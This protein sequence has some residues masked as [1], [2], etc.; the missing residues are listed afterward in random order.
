LGDAWMPG[1]GCVQA[2]ADGGELRGG[3]PRVVWQTLE[4]DPRLVSARS[5][6]QCLDE[7]GRAPHLV[8]NP[9]T[10]EAVQLIPLLRAGRALGGP[11]GL[12]TAGVRLHGEAARVNREGRL[13][14]QIAV[15]G[16]AKEP[17]TNG[18]MAGLDLIL[19]WLDSWRIPQAWPAGPPEPFTTAHAAPR[20]RRLWA[21]GGHFGG[22]QVPDC[23]ATGPGAVEIKL[24][25]SPATDLAIEITRRARESVAAWD[26][27]APRRDK[28]MARGAQIHIGRRH[29]QEDADAQLTS[30]A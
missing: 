8:W 3:A 22:S 19:S 16:F 12:I 9:L 28:A 24:L 30:T 14:V 11:D 5:A 10:G 4:T 20:Y 25:A 15:V 17:F 23:C 29:E 13:C 7:L 18:P 2:S 27:A 26:T 6:A 21:R 1:A